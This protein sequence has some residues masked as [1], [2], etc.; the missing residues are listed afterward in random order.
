M[1]LFSGIWN[2]IRRQHPLPAPDPTIPPGDILAS[3]IAMHNSIRKQYGLGPLRPIPA[4]MA[5]AAGHAQWMATN[6]DMAHVGADGDPG[7]RIKAAGYDYRAYGENIAD[8]Y[9]TV[10][11]VMTGWMHSSG[12]RRN[13]LTP[14][15]TD[16]GVGMVDNF[17]CVDFGTRDPASPLAKFAF[18]G[19][20]ANG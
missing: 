2:L 6:N 9:Q 10:Q 13:I 16:I 8:G 19:I 14:Y 20:K 5:A 11:A 1:G 4:L 17:W 3:L 12:H 7:S 15:F 18:G